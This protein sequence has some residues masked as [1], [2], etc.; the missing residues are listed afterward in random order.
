M[1]S[2]SWMNQAACADRTDLPWI[3]DEHLTASADA[4]SMRSVCGVCPVFFQCSTYVTGVPVVGGFWAGADRD[5]MEPD[6]VV[7]VQDALPGLEDAC[8]D[9][10]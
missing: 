9:V 10:A 4:E 5:V 7:W 2:R 3:V 6:P 1:T 8:G